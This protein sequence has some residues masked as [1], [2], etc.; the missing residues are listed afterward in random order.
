M[1]IEPMPEGTKGRIEMAKIGID[2]DDVCCNFQKKEI[3]VMLEMF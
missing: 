3:E 1:K 2:C